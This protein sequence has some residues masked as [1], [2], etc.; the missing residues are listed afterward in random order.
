MSRR[1]FALACTAGVLLGISFPPIP[2]GLLACVALV[3]FFLLLDRVEK[4]SQALRYAYLTFFVF[5]II[6]LYWIGGFTHGN[7]KFLMLSGAA[8]VVVHPLFFLVPTF[9]YL[10]VGRHLG[11]NA[12][13]LAI[14]FL[15]VGFEWLHSL[16]ELGFPW[17]TLG[18]TQ[19]YAV[20]RIQF[21]TFTGVFGITFWIV[22]VNALVYFIYSKIT[23][24]EWRL[25][26]RQTTSAVVVLI[27]IVLL[28]GIHGRTVLSRADSE[29]YH[30]TLRVGMIQPNTDPWKKWDAHPEEQLRDYIQLSQDLVGQKPMLIIWP[31]TA[32][33][34]RILSGRYTELFR[35][36]RKSV[37]SLGSALLTGFA[38]I[39]FYEEGKAP[40]GTKTIA[41]TMIHYDDFN[42]IM[43]LE[44]G[45]DSI[46]KYAKMKLVPFAERVP[47]AE[48]LAFLVDAVKWNVGIS[49]WGIGRDTT[50]FLLRDDGQRPKFSAMVCYESIYPDLV[51][52]FVRKGAQF[53]VVITNDS[54]WG[55]TSGAYQH[56][57]YATL[58]AI[59][60]RRSIV[61][62][63]NGGVSCFIDPHG[64]IS[65]A[66][67]LYTR[68]ALV[69]DVR[70]SEERTFYSS[71]GDVFAQAC[72]GIGILSIG[73]AFIRKFKRKKQNGAT[74]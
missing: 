26:S 57:Q 13:L 29:N 49:G 39:V 1:N 56:L 14:P 67:D 31:E 66:R 40:T 28:P 17:L 64:R 60:N 58:R 51:A 8:L 70:L 37:D 46:Q 3:P 53:L 74:I 54:W 24:S 44:P 73:G 34:F 38:E 20:E 15:W 42:A 7:D 35:K 68:G 21:I 6:T 5:N 55:N 59:E 30:A 69:G 47:Y 43:L 32:I 2:L 41:G 45:S 65:H 11:R 48:K 61:R 52:S 22:A 9:A 36:F 23:Q 50:V 18:N 62:C 27:V 72:T 4:Y 63:A 16:G 33:S 12:A 10:F 25:V 71:Y 19:T